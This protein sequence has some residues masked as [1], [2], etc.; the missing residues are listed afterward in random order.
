MI[1]LTGMKQS[2][3]LKVREEKM[4]VVEFYKEEKHQGLERERVLE[5]LY[6]CGLEKER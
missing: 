3:L 4:I 5:L 6:G 2:S 1:L